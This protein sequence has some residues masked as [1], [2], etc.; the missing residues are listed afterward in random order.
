MSIVPSLAGHAGQRIPLA[1]CNPKRRRKFRFDYQKPLVGNAFV[2]NDRFV[3]NDAT[4]VLYNIAPFN[5]VTYSPNQ[6]LPRG[7]TGLDTC[8][9]PPLVDAVKD[10]ANMRP[11]RTLPRFRAFTNENAEK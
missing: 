4:L 5:P 7:K 3:V 11:A 10:G 9:S 6:A 1:V 8:I 2:S